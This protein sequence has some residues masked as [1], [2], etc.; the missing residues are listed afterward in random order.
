MYRSE[1]LDIAVS[2]KPIDTDIDI[3]IG[4][5]EFITVDNVYCPTA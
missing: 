4:S 1:R 2:N 3:G 5:A